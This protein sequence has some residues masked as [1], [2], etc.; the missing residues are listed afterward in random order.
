MR[1]K[2]T[3]QPKHNIYNTFILLLRGRQFIEILI[4]SAHLAVPSL[5]DGM[6]CLFIAYF[7]ICLNAINIDLRIESMLKGPH[8]FYL[9]V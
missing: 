9:Y 4:A 2:C 6:Q 8:C 3:Q 7:T 5:Y 1:G